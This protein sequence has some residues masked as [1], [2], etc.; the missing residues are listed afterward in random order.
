MKPIRLFFYILLLF[1]HITLIAFAINLN[2]SVADNLVES[3]GTVLLITLTGLGLFIVVYAFAQFDRRHYHKKMNRLEAEKNEIKA[4]V[5]DMKRRENQIDD[6]IKS[7]ESSLETKKTP[8]DEPT[9]TDQKKL[10]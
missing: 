1:Y 7:F 6:E 4:Q 5:Y 8:P 2:D 3:Q 10:T 9:D